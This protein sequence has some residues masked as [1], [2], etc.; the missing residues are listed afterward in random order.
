MH[1][2]AEIIA[3]E[4]RSP[5]GQN[6]QERVLQSMFLMERFR[7]VDAGWRQHTDVREADI[8]HT[9]I[10]LLAHALADFIRRHPS[11]PDVSSA[12][13]ALGKL[14]D[15]QFRPLFDSVVAPNSIYDGTARR[16]ALVAIEDQI[17]ESEE[18]A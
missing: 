12:I 13:W 17:Y 18:R 4:L 3:L 11:H 6:L 7:G 5:I 1:L 2:L 16:Q 15:T 8:S 9:S 14:R 10:Y